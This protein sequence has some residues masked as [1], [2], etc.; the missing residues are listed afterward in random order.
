MP[1]IQADNPNIIKEN[2]ADDNTKVYC[3]GDRVNIRTGNTYRSFSIRSN[4][5]IFIY[6]CNVCITTFIPYL[7]II[8][9]LWFYKVNI[10]TGPDTSYEVLTS[11]NKQDKMTRI[12][13]GINSGE[14]WDKVRLENG[15][16]GYI[17]STY[18]TEIPK[19]LVYIWVISCKLWHIIINRNYK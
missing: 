8:C 11:L 1:D 6:R 4:N 7:L 5:T 3:N 2:F 16:I 12:Q 9:I 10:R 13:K 14:R 18:V 15:M 17:F 19:A